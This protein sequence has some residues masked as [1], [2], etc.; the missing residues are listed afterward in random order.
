MNIRIKYVV[1]INGTEE[2]RD[3]LYYVDLRDAIACELE[4]EGIEADNFSI[5]DAYEEF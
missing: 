5:I 4:N 2:E 3:M 1:V